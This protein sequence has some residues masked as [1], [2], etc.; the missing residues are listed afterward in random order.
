MGLGFSV[1]IIIIRR[2]SCHDFY[3]MPLL[4]PLDG[5][6]VSSNLKLLIILANTI[7]I[8]IFFIVLLSQFKE[9]LKLLL[10]SILS[11]STSS[12]SSAISDSNIAI[13]TLD[14]LVCCKY[15]AWLSAFV[16][17][18]CLSL[19]RSVRRWRGAR[20]AIAL[21]SSTSL[22][23]SRWCWWWH[24][25]IVVGDD[26]CDIKVATILSL[27]LIEVSQMIVVEFDSKM[28]ELHDDWILLWH[29]GFCC[30]K[31]GTN[32][33]ASSCGFLRLSFPCSINSHLLPASRST[34]EPSSIFWALSLVAFFQLP[35]PLKA[36]ASTRVK[37]LVWI[38]GI[39]PSSTE[40]A[41]VSAA[42]EAIHMIAAHGLLYRCAAVWAWRGVKTNVL[43]SCFLFDRKL[44]GISRVAANVVAVP[45]CVA[46]FAE[47]EFALFADNQTGDRIRLTVS[48]VDLRRLDRLLLDLISFALSI[49]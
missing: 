5:R 32:L 1:D 43:I 40:I 9:S 13:S 3:T 11:N 45:A 38:V 35:K 12:I 28:G 49:R 36:R 10:L 20:K 44:V 31:D 27:Y 18:N 41:E 26:L 30:A 15:G 42:V 29:D 16:I 39:K 8:P 7:A 33:G 17:A 21:S 25:A 24:W 19:T 4:V 23:W 22:C 6:K 14:V 48:R 34:C 46:D 47:S 37:V 2:I